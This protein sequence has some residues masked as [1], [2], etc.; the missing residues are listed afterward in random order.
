VDVQKLLSN[1]EFWRGKSLQDLFFL[2]RLVL[3]TLDDP[4]PGFKHINTVTHKRLCDF[5]EKHAQPGQIMLI[6][7]PR[8]WVKSYIITVGWMIQR[9][10]RNAL[11]GRQEQFIINNATLPNSI[12]FLGK[13]QYNLQHNEFLRSIFSDIIPKNPPTEARR[14]TQ[15]EIDIC[16]TRIETG[17]A[18]GNLVSRHYSGGMINDDLVN[19]ENSA[20]SDQI[21]K[22][23][24]FWRLGQ[25]LK[26][27][28]S[29]EFI[30][31][32]RWAFD[33]LYGELIDKFLFSNL[34]EDEY[35]A[36]YEKYRSEPYFEHHNGKWHLFHASCWADPIHEKG[37]TFPELFPEAKIHELKEEQG[38]RFGGQYLN[39][40]LALSASKFKPAWFRKWTELP[41]V[42]TG[43]LLVDFAGTEN[44]DNDETGMVLWEAGSDK[45]LYC[46]YAARKFATD[47][48]VIEWMIETA[49]AYQPSF[50][51][52]ESHKYGLV[53]ELLPF[54]LR[55][56]IRMGRI[57]KP[58]IEY[59]ERI[60]YRMMELKHQSRNKGLR[61]SN[62]SA[63]FE[64]G[65]M[66]LAPTGMS[67]FVDE[68]L[69]FDKSQRD[70]I[71]DAA[72][73]ILDVVIFPSP[74]D[75]AK[76][77]VVP[78]HLKKTAEQ[79]EEEY[80]KSVPDVV[81]PHQ[82]MLSDDVDHLF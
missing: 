75:P 28:Q 36:T 10:L 72:A 80:W 18:E 27:P 21:S 24:D 52:V 5:I 59:A 57:P 12:E 30:P 15:S 46:R 13:I 68:L 41:A 70:N 76:L 3:S 53:R 54:I 78:E 1:P 20:T 49:C 82:S 60:P 69:R 58:L 45:N 61:I 64:R 66:L 4:T 34:S 44:R 65:Q 6:M 55:Q 33:D 42:R 7:L 8:G 23:K 22:V 77:L 48:A 47:H 38:E 37:S 71:I 43:F 40:P 74:Q 31:G 32:T 81:T 56:M 51:G 39:D 2:C 9:I 29:I 63:W 25:S 19:R 62:M 14:W 50:I 16:G 26:M 79:L 35:K 11:A 17:S 67:D 73:Y